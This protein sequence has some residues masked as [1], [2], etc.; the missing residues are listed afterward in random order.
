LL[1]HRF[2]L[3]NKNKYNKQQQKVSIAQKKWQ[4]MCEENKNEH[5]LHWVKKKN[6][7]ETFK[8]EKVKIS[9]SKT[10]YRYT[11]KLERPWENFLNIQQ[12]YKQNPIGACVNPLY[13]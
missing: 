11:L 9:I 5:V 6:A 2:L 1:F 7:H 3:K 10:V 12:K 8:R 13:T 4:E